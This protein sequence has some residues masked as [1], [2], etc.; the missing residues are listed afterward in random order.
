RA[1]LRGAGRAADTYGKE[2][3]PGARRS[4]AVE[5]RVLVVEPDPAYARLLRGELE[6]HGYRALHAP[7]GTSALDIVRKV[8]PDLAAVA[9]QLPEGAGVR[10]MLALHA[11]VDVPAILLAADQHDPERLRG[12]LLGAD[13]CVTKPFD[14]QELPARVSVVLRRVRRSTSVATA[15]AEGLQLD[16]RHRVARVDGALVQLSAA[17]WRLLERRIGAASSVVPA[18]ELI[19]AA[20]PDDPDADAQ[21]LRVVMSCLRAR[22]GGAEWALQTARGEGYRFDRRR[23]GRDESGGGPDG[24]PSERGERSG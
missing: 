5:T 11:Q 16:V 18:A 4:M 20:W 8:H 21:R 23:G 22:L 13:D 10:F 24:G 6:R 19:A 15:T 3:A 9:T 17:D 14:S 12:L 1:T 7:D 2:R